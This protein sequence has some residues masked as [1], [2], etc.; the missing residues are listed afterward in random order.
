M[1]RPAATSRRTESGAA[2][3]SLRGPLG[4]SSARTAIGDS[5]KGNDFFQDPAPAP[6]FTTIQVRAGA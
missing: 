4:P 1:R 3:R 6:T 5:A 2:G